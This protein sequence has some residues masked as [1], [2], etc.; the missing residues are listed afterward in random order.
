MKE[1]LEKLIK[2]HSIIY[3]SVEG[4]DFTYHVNDC[5]FEFFDYGVSIT[6]IYE[7]RLILFSRIYSVFAFNTDKTLPKASNSWT[8][9]DIE[10]AENHGWNH[11]YVVQQ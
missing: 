7:V 4:F 10:H 11:I 3:I 6:D 1:Y 2:T 5:D 9:D 8:E